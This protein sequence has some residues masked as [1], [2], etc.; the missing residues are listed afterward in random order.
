MIT[1]R[2]IL[3][4]PEP[5]LNRRFTAGSGF[6]GQNAVIASETIASG[7]AARTDSQLIRAQN[8]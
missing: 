3:D 2:D 8:S 1:T 4:N 5:S 7:F 6:T